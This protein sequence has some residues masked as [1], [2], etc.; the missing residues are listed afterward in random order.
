MLVGISAAVLGC[1]AFITLEHTQARSRV[2]RELGEVAQIVGLNSSR[3]L[4]RQ[5]HVMAREMMTPLLSDSRVVSAALLD[6]QGRIFVALNR[7]EVPG[8]IDPVD[9]SEEGAR[10]VGNR[11]VITRSIGQG[12]RNLGAVVLETKPALTLKENVRSWIF[13]LSLAAIVVAIAIVLSLLFEPKISEPVQ[14]LTREADLIVGGAG[15]SARGRSKHR[16]EIGRLLVG[17]N[18]LK[19]IIDEKDRLLAEANH[20]LDERVVKRTRELQTEAVR[21]QQAEAQLRTSLDQKEMLLKEIHHRIKNNLQIVSSLLNLEAR[22]A[23]SEPA[24]AS[25]QSSENRVQSLALMHEMFCHSEDLAEI[26]LG[27]FLQRMSSYLVSACAS[28]SATIHTQISAASVSLG[29]EKAVPFGLIIHELVANAIRHAF[30][31]QPG[32]EVRIGVRN[33]NGTVELE[34][35]DNGVGIPETVEWREPT[36]LG[37]QLV[38]GLSQQLGGS[39]DLVRNGGTT[40]VLRFPR[41]SEADGT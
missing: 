28:E 32:P 27:P 17:F 39:L 15:E 3:P 6:S 41:V 10:R 35:A 11:T 25:L 9:F 40:W 22:Q 38:Q 26:E 14:R 16:D 4:S 7:S 13:D 36:T 37:L 21:W 31:H 18:D 1:G 23:D 8:A 34:V 30:P 24:R 20:R 29:I 19:G 12:R 2:E 5:D 33:S